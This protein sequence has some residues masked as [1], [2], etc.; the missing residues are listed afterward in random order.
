MADDVMLQD[1]PIF[2]RSL[3]ACGPHDTTAGNITYEMENPRLMHLYANQLRIT[4]GQM[5]F[6][7][8]K[9]TTGLASS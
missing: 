1:L 3:T 8:K 7:T 9:S 6:N 2:S 5:Q 4:C